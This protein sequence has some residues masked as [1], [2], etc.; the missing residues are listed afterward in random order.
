MSCDSTSG[1]MMMMSERPYSERGNSRLNQRRW[2]SRRA[3]ARPARGSR[4]RP[5]SSIRLEDIACSPHGLQIA[6]EFRI[7]LDLAAQPRHLHVDRAHIA[8]ELRLLGQRL[9]RY[10]L[11]GAPRQCHEERGLAGRQMDGIAAAV[12]L[13][14]RQVETA[15]AEAELGLRQARLRHAL[16]DIADAQH[17][18]ARLERL[19]EVV[20]GPAL[21]PVGPILRLRP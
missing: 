18:L 1:R 11:A 4:A 14:A 6:R 16:Q 9:A 21:E 15:G 19:G 17:Q 10:R 5:A 7:A 3:P 8:A 12:E 13:A 20:L 2:P